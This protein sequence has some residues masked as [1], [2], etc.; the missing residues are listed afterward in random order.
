MRRVVRGIRP[1]LA[2]RI[3]NTAVLEIMSALS[4]AWPNAGFL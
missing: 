2:L 1:D 3:R 4:G